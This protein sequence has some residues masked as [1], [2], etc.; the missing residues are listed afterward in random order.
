MIEITNILHCQEIP[1]LKFEFGIHQSDVKV[2][3]TPKDV[4]LWAGSIS[5]SAKS[6]LGP[7]KHTGPYTPK[8]SQ[9][10]ERYLISSAI[11]KANTAK[12]FMKQ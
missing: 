4:K 3:K 8:K 2:A 12:V 9:E 5:F 11:G 1:I 10:D 6:I 7:W